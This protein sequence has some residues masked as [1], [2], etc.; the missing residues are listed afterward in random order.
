MAYEAAMY[1]DEEALRKGQWLQEE[2]DQL[3]AFVT[4]LGE[5]RWD[6]LAK[7]AGTYA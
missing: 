3:T 2:D 7:V 1:G 5:R 6:S 4:C